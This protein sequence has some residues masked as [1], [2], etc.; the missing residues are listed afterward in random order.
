MEPSTPTHFLHNPWR[1]SLIRAVENPALA[2]VLGV[3]NPLPTEVAADPEV[4]ADVHQDIVA[5]VLVAVARQLPSHYSQAPALFHG[6]ASIA[7]LIQHSQRT[8]AD[9]RLL[10]DTK[11]FQTAFSRMTDADTLRVQ[12]ETAVE[13][14]ERRRLSGKPLVPLTKAK[15]WQPTLPEALTILGEMFQEYDHLL[16]RKTQTIQRTSLITPLLASQLLANFLGKTIWAKAERMM[17]EF[18]NRYPVWIRGQVR[19]V[20][21]RGIL[22]EP[23][24][25]AEAATLER[26]PSTE[27]SRKS[28]SSL[29]L[30]PLSSRPSVCEFLHGVDT[31]PAIPPQVEMSA[32]P[33]EKIS[34]HRE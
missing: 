26:P 4:T 19:R 29:M 18:G 21:T 14:N 3:W 32:T 12:Y 17:P 23:E 13:E 1:A 20:T 27:L 7:P 11:I 5:L 10:V 33:E 22:L 31:F 34:K 28:G 2:Q 9:T 25:T 30:S 6:V 24:N 16:K 8:T 15:A